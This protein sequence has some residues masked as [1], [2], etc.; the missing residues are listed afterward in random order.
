MSGVRGLLARARRLQRTRQP[1]PSPIAVQYRG[2]DNFDAHVR[3]QVHAGRLDACDLLGSDGVV[4]V[5]ACLRRWEQQQ[6]WSGTS[7]CE[8]L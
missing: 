1:H 7:P 4:G 2:F 3:A 6:V 5:L 8:N